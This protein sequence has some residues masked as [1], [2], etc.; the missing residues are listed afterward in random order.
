MKPEA[1]DRGY[2]PVNSKEADRLCDFVMCQNTWQRQLKGK[3]FI[4]SHS[5]RRQPLMVGIHNGRSLKKLFQMQTK[6]N[7]GVIPSLISPTSQFIAH[8]MVLLTFR[9]LPF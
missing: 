1:D 3:S 7:I 8:G 2:T 4:L 5:L 6:I 9:S